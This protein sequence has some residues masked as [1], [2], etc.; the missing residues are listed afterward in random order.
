VKWNDGFL[1]D[2][3]EALKTAAV[4]LLKKVAEPPVKKYFLRKGFLNSRQSAPSRE[5]GNGFSHTQASIV[6]FDHNREIDV[7]EKA[8]LERLPVEWVMD[9]G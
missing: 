8:F 4:L 3:L 6:N 2:S 9:E 7:W 5:V 1:S